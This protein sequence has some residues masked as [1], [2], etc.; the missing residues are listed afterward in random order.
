MLH[1]VRNP[2]TQQIEHVCEDLEHYL[3]LGWELLATTDTETIDADA[4]IEDGQMVVPIHVLRDRKW[5]EIKAARDHVRYAGCPTPK[6]VMDNDADSQRKVTSAVTMA[7]L[8]GDAFM[9]P[10]T[11]QDNSVVVHTKDDIEAAGLAMGMFDS[12]C[13]AI[14]Q[15]LRAQI[16]AAATAEELEAIQWPDA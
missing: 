3:G 9:V 4:V 15:G 14:G 7:L 2:E 16:E 5:Q 6:G 12:Q 1:T 10:W 11:M 8:L 13:H